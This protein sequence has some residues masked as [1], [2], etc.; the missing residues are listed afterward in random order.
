MYTYQIYHASQRSREY[1]LSLRNDTKP[2]RKR[3]Y[4]AEP[5]G[6]TRYQSY[7]IRHETHQK[8][9][10]GFAHVRS[11]A[12]APINLALIFVYPALAYCSANNCD[13][14]CFR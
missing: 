5:S 6:M 8:G 12:R 14:I 1:A 7:P 9:P 2:V 10:C 4:V 3:R 11:H 13:T